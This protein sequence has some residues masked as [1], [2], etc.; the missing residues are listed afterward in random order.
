MDVL[1]AL[2]KAGWVVTVMGIQSGSYN[3]RK[4]IYNRNETNED[5]LEAV[6][7]LNRLKKIRAPQSYFRIYY[8]YI[9]NNPLEGKEDL[10]E[11]LKLIL[12]LPKGFIFQAFNLSFFPNYLITKE[13][14]EKGF[15]SEE[16]IEGN[17]GTSATN[18]ITTFD[19]KKEYRGF[20]RRHEYYYFL[21]SLAQFKIFPNS[22]IK[23]IEKKKLFVNNL[24]I[25]YW[26]CRIVRFID[27]ALHP[28]NYFWLWNIINM[29][30]LKL[31]IKYRT[32]MRFS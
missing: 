20:L 24:K 30:P 26:I 12:E 17:L 31:K 6:Q 32:L 9:K 18:W 11:S 2:R 25:L 28:S 1:V 27:L 7:R 16:D 13:Y 19:T 21:F 15:L 4:Q 14:L 23:I 29:V 3:L 10:R 8:D 22:L 5:I